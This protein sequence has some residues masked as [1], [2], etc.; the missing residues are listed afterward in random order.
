MESAL[1]RVL[2]KSEEPTDEM[3]EAIREVCHQLDCVQSRFE[4][5][6]DS[7]MIES[8]IFEME[9]LRARYRY[10]IRLAKSRGATTAGLSGLREMNG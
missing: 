7:D 9:S 3:R 10:L 5:E 4:M 8:C 2:F 6:T 1:K